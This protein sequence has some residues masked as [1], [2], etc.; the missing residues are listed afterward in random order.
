MID[1][2]R[3]CEMTLLQYSRGAVWPVVA[4]LLDGGE[5]GRWPDDQIFRRLGA[6]DIANRR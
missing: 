2:R 6:R 1:A 3:I 4:A 5:V